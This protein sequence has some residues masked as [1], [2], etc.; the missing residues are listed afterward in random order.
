MNILNRLLSQ[1]GLKE[2]DLSREEQQQFNDWRRIL[3]K[4]E[5]TIDDVKD[6]CKTQCEII[7][8]KWKDY[9]TANSKKAELIPYFTVYRTLLQVINA[10]KMQKEQLEQQLNNLIN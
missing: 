9:D 6:F 5:L 10:P 1:R 7:E 4:D 8:N 2:E 3:S